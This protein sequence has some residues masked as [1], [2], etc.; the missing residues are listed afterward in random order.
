MYRAS[1]MPYHVTP[2]TCTQ[3]KYTD[4]RTKLRFASA[5]EYKVIRGLA[6]NHIRELLALRGCKD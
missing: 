3:A 6:P 4:P 1:C 5:E 2:A